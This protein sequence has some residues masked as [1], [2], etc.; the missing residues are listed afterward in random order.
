MRTSSL[1]P[2]HRFAAR[3]STLLAAL[4]LL[5]GIT[6]CLS[7]H[8][9]MGP[10]RAKSAGSVTVSPASA[11]IAVGGTV[12]LTETTLDGS[13]NVMKDHPS[14]WSSNNTSVAAVDRS[15]IVSA[16]APGSAIITATNGDLSGTSAIT[17]TGD[18]LASDPVAS[19]SVSPAVD[20]LAVG[21][22]AQLV[23]TARDANG[24]SL[25]GRTVT[26]S[27]DNTA[28]ATVSAS[29]AVRG[30]AVGSARV[31]ATCE[32]HTGSSSV[33]VSVVPVASVVVSPSSA[34][35]AAGATQQLSASAKDAGGHTLTGRVISWSSDNTA[36]ASVSSSGLVR[37]VAAG[38]AHVTASC[39]GH[40]GS[41]TI[42]IA[43]PPPAPTA[44]DLSGCPRFPADNI[45]N[46]DISALP[47]HASSAA[48]IGTMVQPGDQFHVNLGSTN[49]HVINRTGPGYQAMT[50]GAC[51]DGGEYTG[52]YPYTPGVTVLQG[53]D[54]D[55]H[56]LMLD[57]T[58]CM[59]YEMYDASSTSNQCCYGIRW[60]LSSNNLQQY[61]KSSAD[62]AGLPIAAGLFT[63]H[64]LFE[65]RNI[66]HALRFQCQDID[67]DWHDGSW[68]WPAR[69]TSNPGI[70][71]KP[72]LIPFG[73]RI[74]LRADFQPTGAAASDPGFLTLTAAMKKYGAFLGDRGSSTIA[75]S[76]CRDSRWG[77]W[78]DNFM[79]WSAQWI[80]YLEVVDESSLMIDPNSGQSR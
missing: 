33:T 40:S 58:A 23:A 44:G 39:E 42:S 4:L 77:S 15:G 5:G 36:A 51:A 57:T 69:H 79:N 66:D 56:C 80:P 59:L 18:S 75:L 53:G 63:Y 32:G 49:G 29:G 8:N 41:S 73:A 19:V 50:F 55:H 30:I 70:A 43:P 16:V 76:G 71:Y 26:W 21:S 6:S 35:L 1:R 24:A 31:T 11:T 65:L 12:T 64:E 25:G 14:S 2:A 10:A 3:I 74:R 46:R 48:W 68:L 38:T 9:I 22:T 54:P 47:A 72:V 7:L 28:T 45:W 37:G 34:N 20:T 52:L 78:P 27:S 62:E 13:G 60:D 61:G 17:V 67:I